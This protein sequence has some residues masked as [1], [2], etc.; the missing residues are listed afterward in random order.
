M[1]PTYRKS[2]VQMWFF[3]FDVV[4]FDLRPLLQGQMRIAKLKNAYNFR[5]LQS[6][7]LLLLLLQVCYVGD[8]LLTRNK[9]NGMSLVSHSFNFNLFCLI[10]YN[11]LFK[12]VENGIN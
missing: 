4:R 3:D 5:N 8:T 11:S 6:L 12:L 2:W 9:A 10:G 1:K 7:C